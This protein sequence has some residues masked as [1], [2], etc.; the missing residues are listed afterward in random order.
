M[1]SRAAAAADQHRD[2]EQPRP[3][4]LERPPQPRLFDAQH[5]LEL[6][7]SSAGSAAGSAAPRAQSGPAHG[8]HQPAH[9]NE[10]E[11]N[12]LCAL[13]LMLQH[14]ASLSARD[15]SYQR[16]PL[17]EAAARGAATVVQCL[18][19]LG[20]D[21]NAQDARGCT[22]LMLAAM[23]GHPAAVGVLL[24]WGAQRDLVN[25]RGNTAL[26]Y[27]AQDGRA[28]IVRLL[29][30]AEADVNCRNNDGRTPLAEAVVRNRE[31]V[32]RLRCA[33]ARPEARSARWWRCCWTEVPWCAFATT[34]ARPRSTMPK[35]A[36]TIVRTRARPSRRL[37]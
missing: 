13:T 11:E 32:C 36:S 2:A 25:E 18:I 19:Q 27:A 21:V 29:I 34:R 1:P 23:N 33:L 31:E 17:L 9:C 22:A 26:S 37:A 8:S 20:A 28:V 16:T 5:S 6:S 12:V 15:S 24:R 7:Q 4:W 30:D 14:G 3:A 10:C 35:S